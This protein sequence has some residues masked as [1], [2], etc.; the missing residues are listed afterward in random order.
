MLAGAGWTYLKFVGM[1]IEDCDC[2]LELRLTGVEAGTGFW[3]DERWESFRGRIVIVVSAAVE[4]GSLVG[5]AAG[6][7]QRIS[8]S[9]LSKGGSLGRCRDL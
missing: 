8:G 4:G 5:V 3:E 1:F 6:Y 9:V 7:E 2:F